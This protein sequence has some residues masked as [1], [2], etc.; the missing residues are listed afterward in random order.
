MTRPSAAAPI[1]AVL[2]VGLGAYVGGYYWLGEYHE[3]YGMGVAGGPHGIVRWYKRS[4]EAVLFQPA[5][6]VESQ[7]RPIEVETQGP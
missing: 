7:F 6:W 5:A 1:L 3:W 2:A 4:W